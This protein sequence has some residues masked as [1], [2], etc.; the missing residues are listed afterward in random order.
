MP[1]FF[2]IFEKKLLK[3]VAVFLS[4][5]TMLLS[6]MRVTFPL[7]TTLSDKI[8]FTTLQNVLLS[9]NFFSSRFP[10]YSLL[11]FRK[12]VT[13]KFLCFFYFL[14]FYFTEKYF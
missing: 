3:T 14:Q 10:K 11:I 6:S 8:G 13:H 4:F 1:K 5:H 9:H 12:S 7:E 2:I